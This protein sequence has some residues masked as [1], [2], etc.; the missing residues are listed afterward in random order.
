MGRVD[1]MLAAE[2]PRVPLPSADLA[3]AELMDKA[4]P[5][6]YQRGVRIP[7]RAGTYAEVSQGRPQAPS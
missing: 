6:C 4:Q 3:A 5:R 2:D 1:G 7:A